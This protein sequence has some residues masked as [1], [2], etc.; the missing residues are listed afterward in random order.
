M[1][2][3]GGIFVIDARKAVINKCRLLPPGAFAWKL[4]TLMLSQTDQ[5]CRELLIR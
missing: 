4:G 5:L 1:N 3:A 2:L